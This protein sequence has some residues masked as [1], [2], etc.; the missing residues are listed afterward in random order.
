MV[1]N[2]TEISHESDEGGTQERREGRERSS[3]VDDITSNRIESIPG[4]QERPQS[5]VE[6]IKRR[7]VYSLKPVYKLNEISVHGHRVRERGG[8][9]KEGRGVG[10]EFEIKEGSEG[11]AARTRAKSG[12]LLDE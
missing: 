11:R 1:E 12:W 5:R 7:T 2:G 9:R 10:P 4:K 8:R 6:G 3:Q